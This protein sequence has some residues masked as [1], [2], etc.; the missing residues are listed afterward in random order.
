MCFDIRVIL[1]CREDGLIQALTHLRATA[2][3]IAPSLSLAAIPVHRGKAAKGLCLAVID[4][5]QL[6]HIGHENRGSNRANAVATSQDGVAPGH[7]HIRGDVLTDYAGH[8]LQFSL[9]RGNVLPDVGDNILF[10]H[11]LKRTFS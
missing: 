8:I 5:S 6:R 9:Q 4:C 11:M 3:D 1:A 2:C 10:F 7:G